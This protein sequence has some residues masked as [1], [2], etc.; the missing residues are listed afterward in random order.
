MKEQMDNV[1]AE[2]ETQRKNQKVLLEIKSTMKDC[3]G[4]CLATHLSN[5]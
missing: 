5:V 2:T 3:G 4:D 1:S